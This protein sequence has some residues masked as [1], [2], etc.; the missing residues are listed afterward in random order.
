MPVVLLAVVF[1]AAYIVLSRTKFGRHH[2]RGFHYG[3]LEQRPPS[4]GGLVLLP[5]GDQ[6][7]RL[8]PGRASGSVHKG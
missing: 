1:V 8:Y 2:R 4:L 7:H 3:R 6:R 5:E